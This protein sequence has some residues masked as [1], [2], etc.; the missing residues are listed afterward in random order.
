MRSPG[1]RGTSYPGCVVRIDVNHNVVPPIGN[2]TSRRDE[3]PVGILLRSAGLR[4]AATFE[5]ARLTPIWRQRTCAQCCGSQTRAPV[6]ALARA[7]FVDYVSRH[8]RV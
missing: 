4:P 2:R 6:K 3:T 5:V 7:K 8:S 1:L